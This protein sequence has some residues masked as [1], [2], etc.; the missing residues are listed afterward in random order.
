V[1]LIAGAIGFAVTQQPTRA[2]AASAPPAPPRVDVDLSD[3]ETRG[4]LAL[5]GHPERHRGADLPDT[6]FRRCDTGLEDSY[7]VTRD[8]SFERPT[9]A[10]LRRGNDG[11]WTALAWQNGLVGF[12]PPVPPPRSEASP[13]EPA[14]PSH[15][16]RWKRAIAGHEAESFTREFDRLSRDGVAPVRGERYALDGGSITIEGCVSGRY[17]LFVRAN[18]ADDDQRI[19]SLANQLLTFA[20]VASD[21]LR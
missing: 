12:P 9:Y 10:E 17:R 4:W 1:A 20:G 19:A 11:T 8:F 18:V 14:Q 6:L 15:S 7:A 13:P 5:V 21:D 16:K 3:A 2:A